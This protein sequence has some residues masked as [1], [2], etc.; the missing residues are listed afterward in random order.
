MPDG[1]VG[2]DNNHLLPR[3]DERV[4]GLA[5]EQ[6]QLRNDIKE[7]RAEDREY[8]AKQDIRINENKDNITAQRERLNS[9]TKVFGLIQLGFA[10]LITWI[11]V[12]Q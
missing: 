11:K 9:V 2:S 1:A 3:I 7:W 6:H 4:K 12:G 5:K 8:Q 10:S